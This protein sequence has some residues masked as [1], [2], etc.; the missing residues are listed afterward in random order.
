MSIA[1]AE[2]AKSG[3]IETI[4]S[5]INSAAKATW[6]YIQWIGEKVHELWLFTL[7][8]LEMGV[9][10]LK[11]PPGVVLSLLV[12]TI[13]VMKISQHVDNKYVGQV[14]LAAG[15]VCGILT[16]AVMQERQYLPQSVVQIFL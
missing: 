7:P 15:I 9:E 16:G 12:C 4:I 5:G 14:F 6:P 8:Y 1:V 3:V 2:P 13:I 10:F 11:S